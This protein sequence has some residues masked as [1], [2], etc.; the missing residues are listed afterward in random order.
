MIWLF[1][2]GR[3]DGYVVING[4]IRGNRYGMVA[5]NAVNDGRYE[6][7]DI[8]RLHW[9]REDPRWEGGFH[10]LGPM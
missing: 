4:R 3:G 7:H 10:S 2:Y 8:T 9:D 6:P 1:I 5:I